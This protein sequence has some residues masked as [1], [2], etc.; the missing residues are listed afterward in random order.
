MLALFPE[1]SQVIFKG[2]TRGFKIK[3]AQHKSFFSV[4]SLLKKLKK[5]TLSLRDTLPGLNSRQA[6]SHQLKKRE[7][8]DVRNISKTE[9]VSYHDYMDDPWCP[10]DRSQTKD[11]VGDI[12]KVLSISEPVRNVSRRTFQ[13][14]DKHVK[15]LFP[16]NI[17]CFKVHRLFEHE[18]YSL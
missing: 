5:Y 3:S 1:G 9:T 16:L 18:D 10:R 11:S 8:Q 4:P 17:N 15:S 12:F 6:L 13:M 14:N 2:K 7:L